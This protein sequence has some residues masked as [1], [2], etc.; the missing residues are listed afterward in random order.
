MPRSSGP[1]QAPER[2]AAPRAWMIGRRSPKKV[3]TSVTMPETKNKVHITA[4]PTGVRSAC[5]AGRPECGRPGSGPPCHRRCLLA[6]RACGQVVHRP[7]HRRHEQ[8]GDE[9]RGAQHREVVL[10]AQRAGECLGRWRAR[11]VGARPWAGGPP[12]S[13]AGCTRPRAAGPGWS[14]AAL[15]QRPGHRPVCAA[16]GPRLRAVG[17][18]AR[19]SGLAPSPS[20]SVDVE[21]PASSPYCLASAA[22]GRPQSGASA[23]APGA[24]GSM[25][26]LLPRGAVQR[27]PSK[28]VQAGSAA[29]LLKIKD[30]SKRVQMPG[31]RPTQV[32]RA[33]SLHTRLQPGTAPHVHLPALQL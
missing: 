26:A 15:R 11:A 16:A 4:R 7:A 19:C 31:A 18:R 25:P 17:R 23:A 21:G 24:L 14:S 28:E 10:R 5:I 1:L 27:S 29:G 30:S 32:H 33:K 13:P 9:H 6:G 3:C 22:R 12:G 20:A 8:E 2:R